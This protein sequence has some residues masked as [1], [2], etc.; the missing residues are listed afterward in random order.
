MSAVDS[1]FQ[2]LAYD[3]GIFYP[4]TLFAADRTQNGSGTDV[5]Q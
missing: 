4:K 5:A 3:K 2:A 1:L